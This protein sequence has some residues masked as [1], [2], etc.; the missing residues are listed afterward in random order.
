[1]KRSLFQ[2]VQINRIENGFAV[3]GNNGRARHYVGYSRPAVMR[4]ERMMK[5]GV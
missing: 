1:M 5:R 4:F 2:D 3:M